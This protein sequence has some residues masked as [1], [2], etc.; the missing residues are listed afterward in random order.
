MVP[1]VTAGT[2]RSSSPSRRSPR[3]R[4]RGLGRGRRAL[5]KLCSF[6]QGSPLHEKGMLKTSTAT[7]DQA[8]SADESAGK[9]YLTRRRCSVPRNSGKR[10]NGRR[11]GKRV[12]G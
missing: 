7:L 9:Q 8:Q 12:E 6:I 3:R 4:F 5:S 2:S 1:S 10:G 11:R